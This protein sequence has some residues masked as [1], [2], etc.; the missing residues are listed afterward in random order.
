MRTMHKLAVVSTLAFLT[1]VSSVAFGE[2]AG[3]YVD[4]ATLTTKVKAAFVGDKQL[5]ALQVSVE[6]DHGTVRLSGTVDSRDQESEAVKV[7]NQINGVKSVQDNLT[8]R[9]TQEE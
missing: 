1:G 3:Q 8:V 7:A 2:S 5:K 9:N 6:T 4:D